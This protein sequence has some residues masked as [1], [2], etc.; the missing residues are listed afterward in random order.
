MI[1]EI[2]YSHFYYFNFLKILRR[3]SF[4]DALLYLFN[5]IQESSDDWITSRYNQYNNRTHKIKFETVPLDFNVEVFL[6]KIQGLPKEIR[7][8]TDGLYTKNVKFL[9]DKKNN[10]VEV[11]G[12]K[13][14]DFKENRNRKRILPIFNLV[15]DLFPF[16]I[17]VDEYGSFRDI[18]SQY[19]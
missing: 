6:K 10:I 12:I 18:G 5:N 8:V 1:I 9:S 13:F 14:F 19:Y 17:T 15:K 4:D 7:P 2:P 11:D 3:T 16:D